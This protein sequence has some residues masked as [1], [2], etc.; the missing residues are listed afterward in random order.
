MKACTDRSRHYVRGSHFCTF[1]R[2]HGNSVVWLTLFIVCIMLSGCSSSGMKSAFRREPPAS[3]ALPVTP[4]GPGP[5]DTFRALAPSEGLKFTPL[6]TEPLG[7]DTA[8]I[9][10]LEKSVQDLR[11]DF[12]TVVPSLVR[13]VA[14]EKDMK[15]LIGQLNALSGGNPPPPPVQA[16][17]MQLAPSVTAIPVP[18]QLQ[19]APAPETAMVPAI[20]QMRALRI[21]DHG[22]KTRLVFDLTAKPSYTTTITEDEKQ[23][24]V[25]LPGITW[26]VQ[27]GWMAKG[28]DLVS[29]YKYE[30]GKVYVDL[31]SRSKIRMQDVISGEGGRGYRLV[32]DLARVNPL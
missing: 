2:T 28:G 4:K 18:Q 23:L 7:D 14:V 27:A 17:P 29:G 24:I 15:D 19:T 6:F 26:T 32:I 20:G 31:M 5:M 25:D 10:R 13:L 12:D 1:G 8:R 22:D 30:N 11:D 21:G 3:A 16:E 9:D